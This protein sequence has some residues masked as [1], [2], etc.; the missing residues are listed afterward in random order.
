MANWFATK[1]QANKELERRKEENPFY[2]PD[3]IFKWKFTKRKK[4]F[5]VG[6][7]LDWLNVG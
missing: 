5:F 7:Y 4:P 6:T 3:T 2:C 1:R